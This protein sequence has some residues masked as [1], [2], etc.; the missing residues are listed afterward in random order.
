[1]HFG[2]QNEI[3]SL[4]FEEAPQPIG[5]VVIL[6]MQQTVVAIDDCDFAAKAPHRLRELQT[7]VA[8]AKHDQM[9]GYDIEFQSFHV[10]QRFRFL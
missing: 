6:A 7:D 10:G 1:L 9:F 3:D 5:D 2:V 4:V 8:A